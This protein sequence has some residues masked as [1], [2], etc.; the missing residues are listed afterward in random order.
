MK[1][2]LKT[3]KGRRLK[4]DKVNYD[5]NTQDYYLTIGMPIMARKNKKS[6]NIFNNDYFI[7]KKIS[8]DT[9]TIQNELDEIIEIE[10]KDI[11]YLFNLAFCISVHKSQGATF[12]K[13]YAIHEWEKMDKKLKYVALSRAT[14]KSLINII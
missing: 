1:E 12:N 9:I 5:D 10:H 7:V 13:E 3:S 2:Y 6:M 4:I 14:C 11:K 8:K